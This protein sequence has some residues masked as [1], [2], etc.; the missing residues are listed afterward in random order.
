MA[1]FIFPVISSKITA[2]ASI[3]LKTKP[4]DAFISNFNFTFNI[5]I[6]NAAI[7]ALA[8]APVARIMSLVDDVKI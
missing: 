2:I 4:I 3:K 7:R 6:N 8:I 5:W 1:E